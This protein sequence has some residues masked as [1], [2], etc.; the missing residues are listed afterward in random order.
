[1]SILSKMKQLV[2]AGTVKVD[3]EVPPSVEKQAGNV[4]GQIRLQALS[5]QHVV[6]LTAVLCEQWKTGR[7]SDTEKKEF[8]LGKIVVAATFDLK[9][10]E[11]RTFP[12]T[13]PFEL[14]KSNAEALKEKGGAL[15]ALGKLAAFSNNERSRYELRVEADVK[16]AFLDPSAEKEIQ[17][18]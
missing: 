11:V 12:F 15:G 3:V 16:G 5:D 18:V 6:E 2:G 8:E 1:M 17:L 7:G 4:Q 13:L 9:K 10:D 14:I